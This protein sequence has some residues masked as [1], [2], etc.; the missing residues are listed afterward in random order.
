MPHIS[1]K[2]L[3]L[4]PFESVSAVDSFWQRKKADAVS[5]VSA[6]SELTS[7]LEQK[8]G[9]RRCILV[10]WPNYPNVGDHLIWL[11]QKVILKKF[12]NLEIIYQADYVE[13]DFDR[14]AEFEDAV[15]LC[16]GGGNFGDLYIHH[17]KF[18]EDIVCRF[19]EREVIFLP[20]TIHYQDDQQMRASSRALAE[21][22][23]V[24]IFT[25]DLPSY[26]SA[27]SITCGRNV[28][29]AIDSAFAL[30]SIIPRL[31]HRFS[32]GKRQPLYLLRQ[33]RESHV[34][35][36][37]RPVGALLV[38]WIAEDSLEW[39][40]SEATAISVIDEYRLRELIDS[41]WELRSLIHFVRAVCLFSKASY[42]VTDRLHAHILALMMGIENEVYDNSYGKISAFSK[43]WTCDD[44]LV[45][46]R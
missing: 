10:D 18:R 6:L 42:V 15:I 16:Q 45:V 2:K 1:T 40:L 27:A 34:S 3:A 35:N 5:V 44:P 46:V 37:D 17:Q 30:Q 14:I 36:L 7:L 13:T 25:R 19:P 29:L 33:D 4:S 21:R 9:G 41:D 20:Q 8:I 31:A 26:T 43:V 38:D 28:H 39:V 23:N 22:P 24:T 11:G 12:L 32:E